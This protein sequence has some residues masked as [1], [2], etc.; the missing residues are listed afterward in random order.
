LLLEPE[1]AHAIGYL[2]KRVWITL[3]TICPICGLPKDMCVC[4]QI[5]P[6]QQKIRI[7]LE[8]RRFNKPVT[9]IDVID[10]K[11]ANLKRLAQKMKTFAACGGTA[12]KGKIMLQGDQR[13]K[14]YAFFI[15]QGYQKENIEIQ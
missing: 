4:K 7:R 12:K 9:I 10:D 1:T 6:K 5:S 3:A 2:R 13:E 11:D 14:V 8:T 15:E